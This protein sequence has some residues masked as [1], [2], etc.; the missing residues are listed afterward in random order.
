MQRDA[1]LENYC[2]ADKKAQPKAYHAKCP[3]QCGYLSANLAHDF[4]FR[5]LVAR[6]LA[7]QT[8]N[9]R[10][11]QSL[12]SDVRKSRHSQ[13]VEI[14]TF[15]RFQRNPPF[16]GRRVFHRLRNSMEAANNRKKIT[17]RSNL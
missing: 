11:C 12:R 10:G 3:P 17:L 7:F 8:P 6:Q 2:G 9:D 4:I 14:T 13:G 15:C 5:K 16:F 1:S